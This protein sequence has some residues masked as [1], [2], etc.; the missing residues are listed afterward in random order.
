LGAG[1]KCN[2]KVGE[3][4]R[5]TCGKDPSGRESNEGEPFGMMIEEMRP[6]RLEVFWKNI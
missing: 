2:I 3:P 5:D 6:L 1:V 4:W